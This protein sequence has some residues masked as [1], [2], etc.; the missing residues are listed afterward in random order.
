MESIII[1]LNL[2][3]NLVRRLESSTEL[4]VV[5]S[6]EY[7]AW[8]HFSAHKAVLFQFNVRTSSYQLN[9]TVSLV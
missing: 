2:Y 9:L 6:N 3:L 5:Y 4:V 8:H 1:L 7:V